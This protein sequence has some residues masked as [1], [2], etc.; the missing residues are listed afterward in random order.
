MKKYS[1]KSAECQSEECEYVG[2]NVSE[3]IKCAQCKFKTNSEHGLKVHMKRNRAGINTGQ[4]ELCAKEFENAN[5]IKTH[6]KR[7]SY[8][9]AEYQCEDCENVGTE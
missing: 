5:E 9:S 3:K 6:M 8:K 2:K 1:C 7:H 4:C